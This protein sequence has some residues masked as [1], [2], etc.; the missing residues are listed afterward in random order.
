MKAETLANL[1]NGSVPVALAG[2]G[3][4]LLKETVADAIEDRIYAAK[5]AVKKGRRAAEDLLDDAEYQVKQHL[6]ST[7]GMAFGLGL[8]LGAVVGIVLTVRRNS[9]GGLA[10]GR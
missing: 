6:L 3:V 2:A 5:R 8:G 10:T 9:K 4:G 7:M 1:T